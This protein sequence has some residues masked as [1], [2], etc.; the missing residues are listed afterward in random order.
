[1]MGAEQ[2]ATAWARQH[3]VNLAQEVCLGLEWSNAH[4][5]TATIHALVTH[6]PSFVKPAGGR[7]HSAAQLV[8]PTASAMPPFKAAVCLALL[9]RAPEALSATLLPPASATLPP[10]VRQLTQ[11]LLEAAAADDATAAAAV[12]AALQVVGKLGPRRVPVPEPV[13]ALLCCVT[14]LAVS[15]TAHRHNGTTADATLRALVHGL[16][17][18]ASNQS[19]DQHVVSCVLPYFV[20][21]VGR[22]SSGG[23]GLEGKPWTAAT[24]LPALWTVM[25]LAPVQWAHTAHEQMYTAAAPATQ[26]NRT[27]VA[28][29]LRARASGW[30]VARA[31]A[32]CRSVLLQ[33]LV[34]L[35]DTACG[36]A[37]HTQ[38]YVCVRPLSP[39]PNLHHALTQEV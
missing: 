36:C 23:D 27:A 34:D 2:W 17:T 35:T 19:L 5:A 15:R 39:T 32:P 8:P 13:H 11:R 18:G 6:L 4:H 30:N 21:R 33:I 25:L 20:H 12:A 29:S 14:H 1:M 10:L 3:A 28:K 38:R 7:K 26:D 31:L 37:A 16:C 9:T 22:A 24:V